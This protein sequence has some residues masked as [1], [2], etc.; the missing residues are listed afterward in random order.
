MALFLREE[1]VLYE[2]DSEQRGVMRRMKMLIAAIYIVLS[3]IRVLDSVSAFAY[4]RDVEAQRL[5]LERRMPLCLQRNS[6]L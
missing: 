2:A 3:A 5:R 6:K 1:D 4:N